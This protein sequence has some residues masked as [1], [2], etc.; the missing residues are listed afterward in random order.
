M[1]SLPAERPPELGGYVAL[2]APGFNAHFGTMLRH[3][4]KKVGDERQ[5]A[6]Q[7][8]AKHLN[9]G[10]ALHGGFLMTV[11]DFV[12]G[13]VAH[14]GG[15][16][17]WSATVTLN[18]DFLAGGDLSGPVYGAA[19][20]TRKTRSLIFVAGEL[21]QQGRVLMTATGIWKVLGT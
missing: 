14:E 16:D 19:R 5:F 20:I 9:G 13:A 11:A 1:S 21:T 3:P 15:E 8:E 18:T 17:T 2:P 4:D 10:G 6:I 12:L 7:P